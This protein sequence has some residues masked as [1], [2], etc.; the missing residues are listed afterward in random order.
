MYNATT[1]AFQ[2]FSHTHKIERSPVYH[3]TKTTTFYNLKFIPIDQ[4]SPKS[5]CQAQNV[6]IGVVPPHPTKDCKYECFWW[7]GWLQIHQNTFTEYNC[8]ILVWTCA[9]L[10]CCTHTYE[11][12]SWMNSAVY[13]RATICPC[14]C[15]PTT[16]IYV[17]A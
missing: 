1:K 15:V 13:T 9:I 6:Y 2:S 17:H 3:A 16:C 4:S 11:L 10:A 8:T 5:L 12:I 7:V 14:S